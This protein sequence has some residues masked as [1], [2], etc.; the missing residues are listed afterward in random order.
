MRKHYLYNV[1]WITVIIVVSYHVFYMYNAEGV[2]G[3]F[4]R[5]TDLPVQYYDAFQY[6]VYPWFMPVLLII[7]TFRSEGT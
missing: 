1:R 7:N 6:L 2:P 5:I 3:G 4:G